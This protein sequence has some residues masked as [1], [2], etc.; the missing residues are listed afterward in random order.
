MLAVI[1]AVSDKQVQHATKTAREADPTG[2]RTFNVYTKM[3]LASES[4]YAWQVSQAALQLCHD[5]LE[6]HH[7]KHAVP[8]AATTCLNSNVMLCLHHAIISPVCECRRDLRK[9]ADR[10]QPNSVGVMLKQAQG[11]KVA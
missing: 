7:A 5:W 10:P 9:E 4:S 8:A 2:Q 6:H 1:S 3:D 11:S